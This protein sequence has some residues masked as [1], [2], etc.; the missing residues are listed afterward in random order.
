[1][2]Q[3]G[4]LVPEPVGSARQGTVALSL[5]FVAFPLLLCA[6]ASAPAQSSWT[7]HPWVMLIGG[8]ENDRLPDPTLGRFALPGGSLFGVTPG[9]WIAGRPGGR[10]RLDLVGQLSYENFQNKADRSVLGGVASGELRVQLA[11]S[12]LWR[13]MLAGNYYS[14]SAYETADRVGGGLE[15]GIGPAHPRWALEAFGGVEGRRY[16]NLDTYNDA[17]VLG[18]YTESGVS[19]GLGGSARLGARALFA[20]RVNWLRVD[21]RDPFYDSD[22][23]LAQGSVRAPVPLD[24]FLTLSALG[25]ERLY[26]SRPAAQDEDSYWQV[27]VGLDR[28]L[29]RT[30]GL[31]ARYAFARSTDPVYADEDL[32]RVT[33]AATWGLGGTARPAATPDLRLP[34]GPQAAPLRANEARVFRCR[35]ATAREVSVVG[36]FNGWDPAANPLRP[37]GDG[38]WQTEVRLPEGSHE[39]TYLVDGEAV[40]P[41]DADATVDDGF[42]GRNG[43]IQ[44]APA[45]P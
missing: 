41:A 8:Y 14:D 44:V 4:A 21:S 45:G 7:S 5:F 20:G 43:L 1:M 16:G 19:L 29:T 37:A 36:D 28:A 38:R 23:W 34:S 11:P 9:I 30:V 42:G 27:G 17:G 25:Q 22:S 35:A 15:V 2:C 39:Y 10:S 12:W 33:L 32:H 40:T 3:H 26:D 24:V 31:T 6:P 18:T 13:T